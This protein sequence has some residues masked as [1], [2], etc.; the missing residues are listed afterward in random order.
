MRALRFL[1]VDPGL[2]VVGWAR[3]G[4]ILHAA[5]TY[6]P[7]AAA[8]GVQRLIAIRDAVLR[9]AADCDLV[10]IEG[11]SFASRGRAIVS[12]GEL[13]GVLRVGLHEAGIRYVDLAPAAVKTIATGRGNASKEE[14]LV[15]AVKRLDYWGAI[16]DVADAL[17]LLEAA[18][19]Q[20]GCS[21]IELPKTHVRAL[22]SV[23]W[24]E[25]NPNG[26]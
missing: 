1:G 11:P 19:Q 5:G 4:T 6:T 26:R 3:G 21:P 23:K 17:W 2:A 15:S 9:E 13:H 16:P 24:P 10:V 20:Y 25:I 8:R 22:R 7:P 18:R 12:L 14:V